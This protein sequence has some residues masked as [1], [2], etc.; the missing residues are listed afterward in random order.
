MPDLLVDYAWNHP[1]PAAIKAS[2]YVG[3]LRYLSTDPTKNLSPGERDLL[4]AQGLAIGLVWETTADRALQGAQAGTQDA[5]L[6]NGQADDL[7]YPAD[8]CIYYAVDTDAVVDAVRPYFQGVVSV[9]GRPAGVYG[10]IHVVD[11]LLTDGTCKFGWQTVAW[12]RGVVSQI[13]HLY[14]RLTPTLPSPGGS[15]DE[16]VVLP[17]GETSWGQWAA[18]PSVPAP[19]PPTPPP[20]PLDPIDG[21]IM[22]LPELRQES[23]GHFVVKLQGLLNAW[24]WANLRQDGMFGPVTADVV[25][26]WQAGAGLVVDGIVGVNTWTRLISD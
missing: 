25:R 10:G 26:R 6:A 12:S 3:V 2:G 11:P 22:T 1:D 17:A 14:Q 20:P 18:S 16:D 24:S 13:A 5:L 21:A 23:Q 4:Q 7:G 15:Y 9:P 8:S 19:T